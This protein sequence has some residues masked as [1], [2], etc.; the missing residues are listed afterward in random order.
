MKLSER[1]MGQ[2]SLESFRLS[3]SNYRKSSDGS[4]QER[5]LA[6]VHFTKDVLFGEQIGEHK[7]QVR[8]PGRKLSQRW[9]DR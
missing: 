7:S 8:R 4:M 1:E 5:V 2:E 9:R 6:S 3:L